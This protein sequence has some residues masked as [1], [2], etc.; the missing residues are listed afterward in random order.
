MTCGNITYYILIIT[1]F[2][3]S[4]CK[5]NL[6]IPEPSAGEA[7]FT[8]TIA[9][10]GNYLAGYSDGALYE[11]GQ[12]NSIPSLIAEQLQ[13]VKGS[14]C[15]PPKIPD[16]SGLGLN[17][18]PW[19]SPFVSR[20][21]LGYKTDCKG[22]KS[23]SPLKE[24]FTQNNASAYLN[25]VNY[26][27]KNLAVPFATIKEFF[28]PALGNSFFSG[29]SNPFYYR[30]ASQP[31]TSTVFSDAM[32][33]DPTFAMVWVGMEDIYEYA[34]V[35]GYGKTI[36]PAAEFSK[37]LD[38]L[39]KP[40]A[41]K[42]AKGVIA[43]IPDLKSFPFYTL[44]PWNK[45]EITQGQ[46]DTLND[47][48]PDDD[49]IYSSV[50]FFAGNNGFV[51]QDTKTSYYRNMNKYEKILLTVPLD[52][53]K[54]FKYGLVLN[55]INDRY[56]MDIYEVDSVNRAIIDYNNIIASKA[57]QYGFAFVDMN[58]FFKSVN[59]GIRMDGIDFNASFVSG[60]FF[61]LDGYHPNQ[62]GYAM[63]ANEFI[64]AINNKYKAVIPTVYCS[65]CEGVLFP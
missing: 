2:I 60:G 27:T 15:P 48:Y 61:G 31:G 24:L 23:L 29:N 45:A 22:V 62:K 47:Q 46:A 3:L 17:S 10:G 14:D 53:M 63:I 32:N 52:S 9:I 8:R 25:R 4:S 59:A 43:N 58:K 6:D 64:K 5:P 39:L 44:I 18:K 20:S 30:F 35:G 34:R 7:D 50:K 55:V 16:N 49:P 12:K 38:S 26:E 1:S 40:M 65:D 13:R 54:C 36:L 28:N 37:Y 56:A 57:V 42:G 41:N 21:V 51:I 19:E 33:I 11:K